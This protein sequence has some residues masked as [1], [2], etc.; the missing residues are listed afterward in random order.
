MGV[1]RAIGFRRDM[2]QSVFLVE[3]LFIQK[4]SKVPALPI[5]GVA[6]EA[7]DRRSLASREPKASRRSAGDPVRQLT[8]ADQ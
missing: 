8:A 5:Q 2:V 1:L 6:D 7:K 4:G 3:N